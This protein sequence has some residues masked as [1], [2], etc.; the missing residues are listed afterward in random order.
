[1][2]ANPKQGRAAVGAVRCTGITGRGNSAASW[3]SGL[4][5]TA[6]A[7]AL[8]LVPSGAAHAV[9]NTAGNVATCTGDEVN[10]IQS[11]TDFFVPPVDILNVNNLLA[12]GI[13]PALTVDGINFTANAAQDI[14]VNA[15]TAGTLGILTTGDNAQGIFAYQNGGDGAVTVISTGNISTNG[16]RA[17]GIEAFQNGGAGVVSVTSTG[18]INTIGNFS[19]G[20]F[21]YQHANDGDVTVVSVGNIGTEGDTAGGIRAKQDDG[22]GDVSVTV[23]G[24][25]STGGRSS[26][27]V[28]AEQESGDG[29]VTVIFTGNVNT[30]G[31]FADGVFAE[32][33]R[34]VGDVTV[35]FTGNITTAG[36]SAEGIRAEQDSLRGNGDVTVSLTG[37]IT[38]TGEGAKGIYADNGGAG[39]VTVTSTGN[40][41]TTGIRADG[42][43]ARHYE[44]NGNITVTSIGNITTNTADSEGIDARKRNG[45]GDVTI[46]S[47]GTINA[48]MAVGIY[49]YS[50][51]SGNVTITTSGA[52]TGTTGIV[53]GASS[54]PRTLNNSPTTINT[55]AVITGTGG[56]AIN[57]RGDG[58]DTVNL[59]P[60]SVIVGTIDFGNGN[61][62]GGAP[63]NPNDIDTLDAAPGVNAIVNFADAGGPD[64][65]GG[66]DVRSAPENVSGNIALV[67]GGTT[68]VAIDPTGFSAAQTWL[69]S[70]TDSIFGAIEGLF[71]PGLDD[72]GQQTAGFTLPGGTNITPATAV[73]HTGTGHR[74]WGSAFGSA[75][76]QDG[77][78]GNAELDQVLG[79]LMFGV[80]GISG[81]GLRAGGFAGGGWSQ[82]DVQFGAQRIGVGT[83]FGGL[84][85]RKDWADHWIKAIV[86]GG[87]AHHNSKRQVA[88][89]A[90]QTARGKYDGYFIAPGLSAGARLAQP[91][92]NHSL[93]TSVRVHYGGLFL[94]GYR[95]NGSA[96]PL[97]VASRDVHVLNARAQLSSPYTQRGMDGALFRFEGRI[98]VDADFNLGNNR[99][100]T[101][102]AG[103]PF[104]FNAGFDD[105]IVS[106]FTGFTLSRTSA[107]GGSVFQ[108]NAELLAASDGSYE[109][110]GNLTA[111]ISF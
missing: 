37:N 23:T 75:R 95:E 62:P 24:D 26:D 18:N 13:G 88:D 55:S 60:G 9:C 61:N 7:G 27:A 105:E 111:K 15:D 96:A 63:L 52:V 106:A 91:S 2:S 57:L 19:D 86:T 20:I 108:A 11:G 39:N 10:G 5:A 47:T 42:I 104:N 110:R 82:Q 72:G 28:K 1:M 70:L 53:V 51:V 92:E 109:A 94:E 107:E 8:L 41:T 40:I 71:S 44:E 50:T 34:G 101:T 102:V 74:V 68:A 17:A 59:L 100:N 89:A 65:D 76:S 38:T 12:A 98:G 45:V 29:N 66:P 69:D 90:V 84:Y 49:A 64:Q 4:L 35:D 30:I 48:A 16:E 103:T 80:E 6:A 3:R 73:D 58:N 43:A 21:A 78:N 81:G 83:A 14:T 22:N 93:W 46:T 36:E 33:Q 99:V 56:T 97:T 85:A 77:G 32:Q 87:Y 54:V 31:D 79:G 67:N 25:I